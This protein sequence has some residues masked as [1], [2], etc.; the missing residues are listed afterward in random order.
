MKKLKPHD[1]LFTKNDKGEYWQSHCLICSGDVYAYRVD[2]VHYIFEDDALVG[3]PICAGCYN[4]LKDVIPN[5][6]DLIA[7]KDIERIKT[8]PERIFD[9][10]EKTHQP[11]IKNNLDRWIK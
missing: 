1:K 8:M 11:F 6:I 9:N 2:D 7:K 5:K 10:I 4:D 3:S